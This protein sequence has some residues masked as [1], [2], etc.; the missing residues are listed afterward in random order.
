M[1]KKWVK[2]KKKYEIRNLL[3]IIEC[4]RISHSDDSIKVLKDEE[5]I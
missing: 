1:S 4:K 5:E 3:I 2:C